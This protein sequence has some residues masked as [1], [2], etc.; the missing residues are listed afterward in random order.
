M[1]FGRSI[2]EEVKRGGQ[3]YQMGRVKSIILGPSDEGYVSI[4]DIGKITFSLVYSPMEMSFGNFVTKPAYPIWGFVKQFPVLNEI[5]LILTG[6]SPGLNDSSQEQ[7]SFYFPP[8][9]LWND[10]EQNA[11]PDLQEVAQFNNNTAQRQGYSTNES[12]RKFFPLGNTFRLRDSDTVRNLQPFEG[13]SI[14]Q[15]RFG[16]SIRFGSTNVPPQVT[17]SKNATKSLNPWSKFLGAD[18]NNVNG[19]P[20][21]IILNQQGFRPGLAKFDNLVEEV[22]IDGSSIYMTSTQVL[23]LSFIQN[24]FPLS[25]FKSSIVR[26][27]NILTTQNSTST[28]ST[29]ATDQDNR[30]INS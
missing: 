23:D 22:D 1:T 28:K 9:N 13:D 14:L 26:T 5:V 11:F 4:S 8:Y 15:G 25:S 10:S 29:S 12:P 16:Q 21:T 3:Y 18:P 20:I 30:S 6:P 27:P 19:D 7:Q 2:L 17:D 24:S